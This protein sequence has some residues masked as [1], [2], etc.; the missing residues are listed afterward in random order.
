MT[1]NRIETIER[2]DKDTGVT[3]EDSSSTITD[4]IIET[5]PLT[6][7]EHSLINDNQL[8]NQ[9]LIDEES[10]ILSQTDEIQDS[11]KKGILK[12]ASC[13][14]MSRSSTTSGKRVRFS[15]TLHERQRYFSRTNN[16]DSSSVLIPKMRISL[17][18]NKLGSAQ[19]HQVLS[20]TVT[21]LGSGRNGIVIHI[22]AQ[23]N[24]VAGVY[25]H[26]SMDT[27][28]SNNVWSSMG[29]YIHEEPMVTH[30]ERKYMSSNASSRQLPV[31][32]WKK[33]SKSQGLLTI[34]R[35]ASNRMEIPYTIYM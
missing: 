21:K 5:R 4:D 24:G 32:L 22:P 30:Q 15:E 9:S 23:T 20:S 35:G 8:S 2:N 13:S 16:R 34:N 28:A 17:N 10:S 1:H 19:S 27:V 26:P 6:N 11:Q 31:K 18:N 25:H 33:P 29:A 3:E 7:E 14:S 12:K